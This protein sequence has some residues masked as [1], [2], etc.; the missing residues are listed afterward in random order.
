D[1]ARLVDLCSGVGL[2]AG[3]VGEGRQVVGVE[4]SAAAVADA[5]VNLADHRDL[6]I[7]KVALARWRPSPAEVVVADPA[8]SG[9]GADGV[10]AVAATGAGLCVLVSCDPGAL[11]RDAALLLSAGF[12]HVGSTVVDLFGHAGHVEVV[13]GFVRADGAG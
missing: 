1:A 13:S 6:R 2:F 4:R 8:R 3:T 9:L 11:G 12:A 10:A 7:I 5:R